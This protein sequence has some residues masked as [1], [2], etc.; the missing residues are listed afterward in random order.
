MLRYIPGLAQIG[1]QGEL[2]STETKRKYVDSTYKN[3]KVIEFNIQL[4]KGHYTNFQDVHLCFPLKFKSAA[5]NNNN[6]DATTVAVNNFFAHWVKE[7]DIK[8]SGDNIP[9][10]SLTNTFD[11]YWD[12]VELLKHML[13]KVLKTIGKSLLYSKRSVAIDRQAHHLNAANAANRMDKNLT[14]RI[15]KFANQLQNEFIYR[16]PL[17]F[18]YDVGLV[19]QHFEFNTNYILILETDMQN[20]FETNANQA[21]NALSAG[22]DAEMIITRTPCIQYEQFQLDDNFKMCLKGTLQPELQS[23]VRTRTKPTPYQKLYELVIGTQYQVID[24]TG[25][26]KQSFFFLYL[27]SG[28]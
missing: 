8:R 28:W 15:A 6:L 2:Y 11:I 17:K 12:S 18:L 20:M 21:N 3:K 27:A 14:D 16:T 13:E 10:L 9:I 1:Y 24:F 19:N 26:N 7:I 5:N 25:A 22:A 4:T 23:V